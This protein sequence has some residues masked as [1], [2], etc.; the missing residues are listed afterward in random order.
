[1]AHFR[2]FT[3]LRNTSNTIFYILVLPKTI[4][5]FKKILCVF[6]FFLSFNLLSQETE[7]SLVSWNI[8]D[9][10]KTKNNDELE[11]IAEIVR[12]AD[13]LAI[14][15]VVAGYGGAQAVAKLSDILNRKGSKWDYVI[16]KPTN[17]SKYVT[18][19][20]AFVWKTKHIKIKNRGRLLT[21][22]DSVV[23]REPFLLEFYIGK[24]KLGIL[25]FHSRPYNKNPQSEVQEIS[26]FI[27]SSLETPLVFTGDFNMNEEDEAFSELLNKGFSPTIL[28]QKTT[29]KTQC[30]GFAYLN[31][32]IDNMYFSKDIEKV[33]G[34]VIDFVRV[35]DRVEQ[36]RKLSDHL[37]VFLMFSFK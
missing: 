21:E 6:L 24:S 13:I 3:D 8:R 17:S 19:R 10:G 20:Y 26:K 32:V 29:L 11:K 15:E 12:E 35:C 30:K 36:A 7:I 14:Q 27:V 2:K 34:G 31:H 4:Q 9:F 25:N 37:P 1:M 23:D 5:V 18:E 28:N 16:S 33:D 22:L